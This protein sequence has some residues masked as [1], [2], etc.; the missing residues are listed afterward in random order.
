MGRTPGGAIGDKMGEPRMRALALV[1]SALGLMLAAGCAKSSSTGGSGGFA[2]SDGGAGTSGSGG[3]AGGL[4]CW[5]GQTACNG[6]PDNTSCTAC[7]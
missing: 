4:P 6:S 3:S 7:S 1:V 2:A 5:S